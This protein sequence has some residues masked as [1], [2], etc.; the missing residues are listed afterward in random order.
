MML[1]SGC[2]ACLCLFM[3]ITVGGIIHRLI[4]HLGQS[5]AWWQK[6]LGFLAADDRFVGRDRRLPRASDF[7]SALNS[8][9]VA[10]SKHAAEIDAILRALVFKGT[11]AV[12]ESA[13]FP[14]ETWGDV[15]DWLI[16]NAPPLAEY[17]DKPATAEVS[18]MAIPHLIELTIDVPLVTLIWHGP[19][20][21]AVRADW[22]GPKGR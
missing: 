14:G 3:R 1:R 19:D 21:R 6:H 11:S 15:I 7:G 16:A 18:P 4:P 12:G 13:A 5:E 22:Y 9:M 17:P 10:E 20:G 8:R 2:E